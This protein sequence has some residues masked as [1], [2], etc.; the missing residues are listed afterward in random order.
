MD[1][2]DPNKLTPFAEPIFF[3]S[4]PSLPYVHKSSVLL[5]FDRVLL[6]DGSPDPVETRPHPTF[7]QRTHTDQPAPV[8]GCGGDPFL[9]FSKMSK[10]NR[11]CQKEMS[12]NPREPGRNGQTVDAEKVDPPK[13]RNQ[14]P[15]LSS[16]IG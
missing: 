8:H 12:G 16:R 15:D 6:F 1:D 7:K 13:K 5:K 3:T 14:P 9:I 11:R 2:S 10:N 4:L